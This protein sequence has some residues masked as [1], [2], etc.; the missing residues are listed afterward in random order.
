M[1][2][3]ARFFKK[4][5]QKTNKQ[6]KTQL[7]AFIKNR[8]VNS[9]QETYLLHIFG[10]VYIIRLCKQPEKVRQTTHTHKNFD[11]KCFFSSWCCLSC[12]IGVKSFYTTHAEQRR[13]AAA[14]AAALN[15]SKSN[16]NLF[17]QQPTNKVTGLYFNLLKHYF[18]IVRV[19]S[20]SVPIK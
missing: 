13:Q 15:T 11:F 2:M 16:G 7:S 8:R 1:R 10:A 17:L 9:I 14:A 4:T 18:H 5:K 19:S 6:I 12:H 20:S 3:G